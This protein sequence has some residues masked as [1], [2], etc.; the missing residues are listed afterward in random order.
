[1]VAAFITGVAG[2]RLSPSEQDFLADA[3]PCGLILFARNCIA[4]EQLRRLIEDFREATGSDSLIISIDQEGGRVQ[5]LRPPQWRELPPAQCYGALYQKNQASGEAATYQAARLMA[6]EL[7]QLG[8]NCNMVPVLDLPQP[9]GHEIISDRALGCDVAQV[10][11][12]GRAQAK[13]HMDSGVLPVMKHV[14]GHGRATADSHLELPVVVAPCHD[15][16]SHDFLPFKELHDLPA[17]MTAHVVYAQIDG[18]AP[19]S[20]SKMVHERIIRGVIG[21]DGLL[22]SDDLSM[23]ALQGDFASRTRDV[24]AAGSDIA[25][26]CNGNLAEM[27]QIASVAPPLAGQALQRFEAALA[28]TKTHQPVD[29]ALG[30]AAIAEGLALRR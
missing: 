30:E 10:A 9:D 21:F 29:I 26:H 19:A 2:P 27:V 15:L 1:M 24:L 16:M 20:T 22:M 4:P 8:I 6:A 13:G 3:K 7:R 12:L 25:L 18:A 5:R 17:A 14:P 28:V 23:K 11:V